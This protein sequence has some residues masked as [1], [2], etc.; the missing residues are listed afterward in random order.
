MITILE[1]SL[2]NIFEVIGFYKSFTFFQLSQV[3]SVLV[4]PIKIEL[5]L[6]HFVFMGE[7]SEINLVRN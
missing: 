2:R 7:Q 1:Y 5:K 4:K 6:F 3:Y